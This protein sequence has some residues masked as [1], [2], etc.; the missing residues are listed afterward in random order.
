MGEIE[1]LGLNNRIIKQHSPFKSLDLVDIKTALNHSLTQSSTRTLDVRA[2]AYV[3]GLV[4]VPLLVHVI[5]DVAAS[6]SHRWRQL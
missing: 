4:A 1:D 3:S 6:D 2:E 5:A